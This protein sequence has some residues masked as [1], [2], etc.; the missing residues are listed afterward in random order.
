VNGKLAVGH[1]VDAML[2][3]DRQEIDWLAQLLYF[4]NR[5]FAD[6]LLEE[7]SDAH[8]ENIRRIWTDDDLTIHV[9]TTSSRHDEF[10]VPTKSEYWERYHNILCR[11]ADTEGWV[12][13]K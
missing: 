1:V 13:L 10:S 6:S 3:M 4:K 8:A 12:N 5:E 2:E 7:L 9:I 11:Y